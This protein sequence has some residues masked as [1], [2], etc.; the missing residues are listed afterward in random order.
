M[1]TLPRFLMLLSLLVLLPASAA[2]EEEIPTDLEEVRAA[3]G[4]AD[5]PPSGGS[6]EALIAEAANPAV[7]EQV[8]RARF[9]EIV[10][11]GPAVVPELIAIYK[12][13]KRSDL[14]IWVAA[15]ALGRVGGSSARAGLIEG[16]SSKKIMARLGSVSGLSLMQDVEAVPALEGALQDK[17]MMVRAAAA[18]ALGALRQPRSSA[19]LSKALNLPSNFKSG[20]SLFVRNHIVDAMGSIGSLASVETLLETLEDS[21]PSV[22]VAA[23]RAL[24]NITGLSFGNGTSVTSDEVTSWKNWWD[25]DGRVRRAN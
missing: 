5:L 15:R 23:S 6:V 8:A 11:R 24:G 17:A 9:N 12:D 2:A 22:Q 19:A 18:D 14:E 20:R 13:S 25:T 21:D 4:H 16:L 7:P 1:R 10:Q 3:P